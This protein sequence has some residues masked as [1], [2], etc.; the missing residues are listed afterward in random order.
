[1]NK[2]FKPDLAHLT[3]IA[4][5]PFAYFVPMISIGH[6]IVPIGRDLD[7]AEIT[8][9]VVAKEAD[10]RCEEVGD[11]KSEDSLLPYDHPEVAQLLARIDAFVRTINPFFEPQEGAESWGHIL[12]PGQNTDWHT[13]I[14]SDEPDGLSWVYY[15]NYPEHSG[16]LV[17]TLDAVARRN[18]V[19][20]DPAVGNLV[21]FPSYAPHFTRRNMSEQKRVSISG[22]YFP[23]AERSEQ[24][25]EYAS[26][27][28]TPLAHILG[29][30]QS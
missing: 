19:E 4:Q 7:N 8:R 1:M 27:Q 24:F 16:S 25:V 15:S 20:I 17:F 3:P 21:I 29:I 14:R 11:T 22:N 6:L 2:P 12:N 13:H 5:D 10:R 23:D 26:T 30:W 28:I 9:A 18:L